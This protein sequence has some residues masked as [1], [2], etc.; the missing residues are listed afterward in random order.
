MKSTRYQEVEIDPEIR[1]YKHL[2][3][4]K[5]NNKVLLYHGSRDKWKSKLK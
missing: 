1:I 4:S 2:M 5:E 3:F